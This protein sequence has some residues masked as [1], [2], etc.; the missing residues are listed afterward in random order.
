MKSLHISL[1]IKSL[2]KRI[3]VIQVPMRDMK[4]PN[5]LIDNY[6][7]FRLNIGMNQIVIPA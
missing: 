4:I 1:S 5:S 2:I 7:L 3:V 6:N